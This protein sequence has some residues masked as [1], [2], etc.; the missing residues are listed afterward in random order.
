VQNLQKLDRGLISKKH[1]GSLQNGGE[2]WL[3]IYFSTDK[4]VDWPGALGP[5]W[6]DGDADRGCRGMAAR[7]PELSLWP[8]QCT[9]AHRLG[10]N[11]ERRARGARLGPHRSSGG[12][13][14]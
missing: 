9:K 12:D 14:R 4:V 5:P 3:G 13:A 8:L 10:R 1:R 11:R 7:S 2:F 6:T